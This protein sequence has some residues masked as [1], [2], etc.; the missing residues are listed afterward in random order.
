V[1]KWD[2]CQIRI[3]WISLINLFVI[4]DNQRPKEKE[5]IPFV[6]IFHSK[7]KAVY[8]VTWVQ[9]NKSNNLFVLFDRAN[10]HL[11]FSDWPTRI[12]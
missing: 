2:V 1:R 6:A 12:I 9:N 10:K 3:M 8:K 11:N 7:F 4:E 5:K